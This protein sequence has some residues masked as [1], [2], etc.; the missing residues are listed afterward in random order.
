MLEI[1]KENSPLVEYYSIPNEPLSHM[2]LLA[3]R[4][5]YRG[6]EQRGLFDP[7]ASLDRATTKLKLEVNARHGRFALRSA[8]TLPLGEIYQD[9]AHGYE[10][11]D[12]HGKTC[13]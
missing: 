4:L 3:D 13:F 7:P 5:Q 8:V 11:C 9:E 2:D 1:V 12:I 6:W 10:V